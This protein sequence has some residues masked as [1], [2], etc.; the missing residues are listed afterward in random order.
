VRNLYE[1]G[2]V[3]PPPQYLQDAQR[4]C[5]D[6]GYIFVGASISTCPECVTAAKL[7]PA[8]KEAK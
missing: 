8:P 6:C 7:L 2:G 3:N 5:P 1:N 4:K